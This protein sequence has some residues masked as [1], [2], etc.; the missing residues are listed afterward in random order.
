[1]HLAAL[2]CARIRWCRAF[3]EVL[4]FTSGM[5]APNHCAE[6]LRSSPRSSR[7]LLTRLEVRSGGTESTDCCPPDVVDTAP[8][9]SSGFR[10]WTPCTSSVR[11]QMTCDGVRWTAGHGLFPCGGADA[12]GSD[13]IG[14]AGSFPDATAADAG[15]LDCSW[16]AGA[17]CWK[18]S[19][20]R[21][22]V[23][24][25]QSSA[26]G[27]LSSDGGTCTYSDGTVVTFATA[28]TVGSMP[29]IPSFTVST[30]ANVCLK[31]EHP[32]DNKAIFTTAGGSITVSLSAQ[33]V[34][35]ITCPDH[36]VFAGPS[37]GLLS[38]PNDVPGIELGL[39]L[40]ATD[41]GSVGHASLSLLGTGSASG[42]IP[43][44]DCARQ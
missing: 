29:R 9:A 20:D 18:A 23:C 22:A 24:L 26:Q 2:A 14:E 1:V 33:G 12:S 40:S 37:S 31:Y 43:V 8:C 7:T 10:C 16:A 13:A 34:F 30:G 25:P 15:S 35:S 27:T 38:C 39:G 5:S 41:A 32:S 44:F 6:R 42:Q 17:N 28:L 19:V 36:G 3:A 21:A 11:Q 4:S